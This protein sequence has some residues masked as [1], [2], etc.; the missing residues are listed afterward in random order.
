MRLLRV[1]ATLLILGLLGLAG[2]TFFG[3]MAADPTEM[4]VPVEL[5]LQDPDADTAVEPNAPVTAPAVP[6]APDADAGAEEAGG[7]EA[8]PAGA[9]DDID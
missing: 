5:Q 9:S 1:L 8:P 2:Y 4:R 6:A 7:T 3:D